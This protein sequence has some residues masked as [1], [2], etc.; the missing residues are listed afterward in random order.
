MCYLLPLLKFRAK[1]GES[2]P[3]FFMKTFVETVENAE[4]NRKWVVVDAA[5]KIVGRV[6]TEVASIL[7]GKR[8][9]RYTPF[10]DTGD[11]VVVINA[12][13]L[14]FTR[15]KAEKKIYYKHTG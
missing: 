6:A 3:R 14:R 12:D 7:R 2:S 15:N 11:F 1:K 10:V 8:N 9:P 5:D 13:K 4:K